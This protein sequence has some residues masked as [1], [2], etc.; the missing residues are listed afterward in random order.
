MISYRFHFVLLVRHSLLGMVF[1]SIKD[2]MTQGHGTWDA[3]L[4]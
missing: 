3:E 4:G 2:E 1:G